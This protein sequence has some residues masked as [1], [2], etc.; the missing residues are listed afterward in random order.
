[1]PGAVKE[2]YIARQFIECAWNCA[3]ALRLFIYFLKLTNLFLR[4][5]KISRMVPA[6]ALQS[7][8]GFYYNRCVTNRCRCEHQAAK[9]SEVQRLRLSKLRC[10]CYDRP[11]HVLASR[12]V[13]VLR[14]NKI[15][16][17]LRSLAGQCMDTDQEFVCGF[18]VKP[19]SVLG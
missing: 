4:A 11:L 2:L 14:T 1:M 17:S 19:R 5:I 13:R 3:L 12:W 6:G 16:I 15:S 10:S 18:L 8:R 9:I 7:K